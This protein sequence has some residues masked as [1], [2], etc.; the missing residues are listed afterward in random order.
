MRATKNKIFEYAT[1]D[2]AEE[3][4][5]QLTTD[6]INGS[7]YFSKTTFKQMLVDLF[8]E[9]GENCFECVFAKADVNGDN[10]VGRHEI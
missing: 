9:A 1:E 4:A 2:E 5:T 3:L 10:W 7:F 8:D 6:Y